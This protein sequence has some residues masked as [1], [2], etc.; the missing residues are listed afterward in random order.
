[1]RSFLTFRGASLFV[2]CEKPAGLESRRNRRVTGGDG[3]T[4]VWSCH[5][6]WLAVA[7]DCG[8]CRVRRAGGFAGCGSSSKR[9]PPAGRVKPRPRPGSAT[10][11]LHAVARVPNL[12]D[13]TTV[14][15]HYRIS[16][17]GIN[18]GSPSFQAA[19]K[20]CGMSG[21]GPGFRKAVCRRREPDDGYRQM[22]ARPRPSP[23]SQTPTTRTITSPVGYG[24]VITHGGLSFAIP[25][26]V[27]SRRPQPSAPRAP[28]SSA[29][30]VGR[31]S[32]LGHR[33]SGRALA[34]GAED[35]GRGHSRRLLPSPTT[36][37]THDC[38][39]DRPAAPE[40]EW[41][42]S[43][44]P[45]TRSQ[46]IARHCGPPGPRSSRGRIA[47]SARWCAPDRAVRLARG[48]GAARLGRDRN[49]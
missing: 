47:R 18:P 12:P 6:I 42:T 9:P 10:A 38:H 13:P 32:A 27:T 17:S 24:V 25:S 22:H 40:R 16:L 28:V 23:A 29:G 30:L 3:I 43:A 19:Q 7:S 37:P 34:A 5:S 21:G 46:A 8:R 39:G 33:R 14:D 48:R 20:V 15:G 36:S 1:V 49:R 45:R 11:E 31:R 35:V 2:R 44:M 26:T 41:R 4:R